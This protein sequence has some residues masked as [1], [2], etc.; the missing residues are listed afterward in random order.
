MSKYEAKLKSG[1]LFDSGFPETFFTAPK[2]DPSLSVFAFSTTDKEL[3]E[4]LLK[5]YHTYFDYIKSHL[6]EY[7]AQVE[8]WLDTLP[9]RMKGGTPEPI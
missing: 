3:I 4:A 8:K 7:E 1:S 6:E 2:I 9:E 5:E